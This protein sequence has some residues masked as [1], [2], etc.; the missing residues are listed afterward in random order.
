VTHPLGHPTKPMSD[1]A[2]IA[3]FKDC[4]ARSRRP[5]SPA[6]VDALA[7]AILS[8]ETIDDLDGGFFPRLA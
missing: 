3:K 4:A 7:D 1:A 2:L 8:L 6:A 5:L